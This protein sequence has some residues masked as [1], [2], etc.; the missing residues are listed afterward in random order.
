MKRVFVALTLFFSSMLLTAA[1]KLIIDDA[2]TLPLR[3]SWNLASKKQASPWQI[4]QTVAVNADAAVVRYGRH[5][6]CL[7][8]FDITEAASGKKILNYRGGSLEGSKVYTTLFPCNECAK[9]IIQV[10]IKEV[11]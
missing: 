8:T 5:T 11:I 2:M 9:A 1:E 10:G 7:Q 4:E 3:R 6:G